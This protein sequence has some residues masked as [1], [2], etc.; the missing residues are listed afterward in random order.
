LCAGTRIE[1]A[2]VAK[3]VSVGVAVL[4]STI[5][6]GGCNRSG[7]GGEIEIGPDEA[8]AVLALESG[9]TGSNVDFADASGAAP[10]LQSDCSF[11]SLR[12]AVIARYDRD[13]DGALDAAELAALR[14]DFGGRVARV[15]PRKL[16]RLERIKWLR[17]IYDANADRKLDLDEWRAL[18]RDLD[19]R[20]QNRRAELV[21]SFDRDGDGRLDAGEWDAARAALAARF[22]E[23]H[24][25]AA[26]ESDVN[27]DG[28]LS[29]RE[30]TTEQ[31][32]MRQRI[33]ARWEQVID[34]F[35]TDSDGVLSARERSAL[36][37][38]ARSVMRNERSVALPPDR[39][40][41]T[42]DA[43]DDAGLAGSGVVQ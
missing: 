13:H 26:A 16:A 38:Y 20:C 29:A 6:C 36:R 5:P 43:D 3:L 27:H 7:P 33:D 37:E 4:C 14:A 24:A 28:K 15:R 41:A 10:V 9:E 11:A 23:Q 39:A 19:A 40:R 12:A 25:R 17:W 1:E 18:K 34:R 31:E 30:R 8:A 42:T 32:R 2:G 35:D 21:R 22:A